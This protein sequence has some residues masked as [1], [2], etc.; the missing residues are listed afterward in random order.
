MDRRALRPSRGPLVIVEIFCESMVMYR[1]SMDKIP[2]YMS[3]IY[4]RPSKS[5]LGTELS[6]DRESFRYLHKRPH[7]GFLG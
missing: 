3:F 6:L 1:S 4:R 5:L 7:T 2:F